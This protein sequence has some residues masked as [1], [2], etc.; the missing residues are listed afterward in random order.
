MTFIAP[1]VERQF[2]PLQGGER[3]MLEG[4]L[5]WHRDTLLHKCSGLSGG[6]LKHASAEPSNLTLLGLV[7]HLTDVEHGWFCGRFA[8][9]RDHPRYNSQDNSDADFEEAG[10]ADPEE[11][12]KRYRV[13]VEAARASVAECDLDATFTHPSGKTASLRWLYLHMIEEYARH[14]GHADL[15]RERVDGTTGG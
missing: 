1:D 8:G 2:P 13:A 6:Q 15:L 3:A 7:R 4:F 5:D 14:N 12:F 10:D 11:A 9:E